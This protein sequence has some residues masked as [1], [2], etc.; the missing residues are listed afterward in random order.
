[1]ARNA[2]GRRDVPVSVKFAAAMAFIYRS[3]PGNHQLKDELIDTW[4]R[5]DPSQRSL[6]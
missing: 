2:L 1:M 6:S 5:V 4:A 3:P